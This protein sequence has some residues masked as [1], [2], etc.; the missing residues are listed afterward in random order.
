MD[1]TGTQGCLPQSPQP[2]GCLSL[3]RA[4]SSVLL[5]LQAVTSQHY[6]SWVTATQEVQGMQE[7]CVSQDWL[8]TNH[9]GKD[10]E[11]TGEQTRV[12]SNVKETCPNVAVTPHYNLR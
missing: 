11:I 5:L 3:Q 1:V 8:C 6:F 7:W 10:E 12:K 9:L 4:H 2:V